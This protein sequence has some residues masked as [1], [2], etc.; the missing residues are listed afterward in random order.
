[1]IKWLL[2]TVMAVHGLIHLMGGF[3]ELGIAKIE[4]LSG[5]TLFLIPD[6]LRTI[7]GVVWLIAVALF[8]ISAL[9]LAIDQRWWKIIAIG[10]VIVSQILVVIWWTDAKWGTIPNILIVI[11]AFL[12]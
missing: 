1:M 4:G 9:G 8:L 12:I 6:T 5:K 11:A 10:A 3:S 7:L 2:V